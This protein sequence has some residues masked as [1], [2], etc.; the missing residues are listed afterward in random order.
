MCRIRFG[1]RPARDGMAPRAQGSGVL[2]HGQPAVDRGRGAGHEGVVLAG[3]EGHR[4]GD[5]ARVRQA[6]HGGSGHLPL[7]VL[8]VLDELNITGADEAQIVPDD[9]PSTRG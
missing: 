8:A 1:R 4:L 7:L 6:A 5:V 2:V 9:Q 3:V